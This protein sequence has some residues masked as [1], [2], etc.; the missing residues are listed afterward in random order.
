MSLPAPSSQVWADV[1]S[2]K[3]PVQFE[4]LAAKIFI[5][6]AQ[7][8]YKQDA[9]VLSQVAVELHNLFEK[10]MNLPSVQRDLSKIL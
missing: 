8:K 7:I 3:K 4:F 6:S 1:I 9:S 5:G 2:G 10:N